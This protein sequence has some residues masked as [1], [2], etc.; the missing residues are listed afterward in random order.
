MKSHI[1]F[2]VYCL[3]T[4]LVVEEIVD[5]NIHKTVANSLT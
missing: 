4:Y 5:L 3:F 2:E 1:S